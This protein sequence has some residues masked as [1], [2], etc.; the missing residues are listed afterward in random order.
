MY[1]KAEKKILKKTARGLDGAFRQMRQ[2]PVEN[3]FA[4]IAG[5][6]S[7]VVY[8]NLFEGCHS[9]PFNNQIGSRAGE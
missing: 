3:S 6:F 7:G 2:C 5:A 9:Q 4:E 8:C 1:P